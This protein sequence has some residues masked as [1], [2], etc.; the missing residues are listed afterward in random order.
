MPITDEQPPYETDAGLAEYLTRQFRLAA[1]E[2][3]V[4]NQIPVLTQIPAKLSVGRLYYFNN[5]ISGDL[6]ILGEGLYLYKS[7]GFVSLG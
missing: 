6:V 3:T 4:S 7:T 5:A 2:D 1:V